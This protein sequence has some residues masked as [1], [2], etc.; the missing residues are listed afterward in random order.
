M[1]INQLREKVYNFLLTRERNRSIDIDELA[2]DLVGIFE[3]SL[4]DNADIKRHI[5]SALWG[6]EDVVQLEEWL[7]ENLLVK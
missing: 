2:D 4:P 7:K 1:N 6:E 3:E 5:I